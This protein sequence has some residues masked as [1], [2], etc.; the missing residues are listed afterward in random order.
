M[1]IA[2]PCADILWG[3]GL[4]FFQFIER[5]RYRKY[6]NA[7]PDQFHGRRASKSTARAGNNGDFPFKFKVNHWISSVS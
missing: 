6:S 7:L 4:Q 1:H 5:P 3:K 2:L